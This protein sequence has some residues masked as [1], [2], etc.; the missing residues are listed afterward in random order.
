MATPALLERISKASQYDEA[1]TLLLLGNITREEGY[2][3]GEQEREQAQEF[4]RKQLLEPLKKFNGEILFL[5]GENEWNPSAPQSIDDLESF[6]QDNSSGEFLPDDGCP[7][8]EIEINED[9]ALIILDSQWYLEDWDFSSEFNVECNIR[10]R[11]R[12][13]IEVKMI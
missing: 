12:F 9:I 10:T 4:L 2:P 11:E 5:P 13:F 8:E 3:E 6:L 1:A 7:V